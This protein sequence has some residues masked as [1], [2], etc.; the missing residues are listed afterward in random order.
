MQKCRGVRNKLGGFWSQRLKADEAEENS[1]AIKARGRGGGHAQG[2]PQPWS[3]SVFASAAPGS[4]PE[5]VPAGM[6]QAGVWE[7]LRCGIG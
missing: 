7:A 3:A 2:P 5:A 1:K 4:P 6:G